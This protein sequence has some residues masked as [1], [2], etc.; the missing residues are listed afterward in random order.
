VDAAEP[1]VTG[2]DLIPPP[3]S[4][5]PNV[6]ESNTAILM[7]AERAGL[8]LGAPAPVDLHVPAPY[9]AAPGAL[10]SIPAGTTVDVHFVH[11]DPVGAGGVVNRL[12]TIEMPREILG[13]IVTTSTLQATDAT[14]GLAA[15]TYPA[16]GTHPDRQLE[17]NGEDLIDIGTD[18]RTITLDLTTSTS[19]DQLRIITL[20]AGAAPRITSDTAA[21]GAAP[22]SVVTGAAESN[23]AFTVFVE[24]AGALAVDVAVDTTAPGTYTANAQLAGGTIAAGT[25]VTSYLVHL[26]SVGGTLI[27]RRGTITFQGPILGVALRTATLDASDAACGSSTT[28]YPVGDATREV[29]LGASESLLWSG[30]GRSLRFDLGVNTGADQLRVLVAE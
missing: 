4:V 19:A 24:R 28:T 27:Y 17:L 26:D 15:V 1:D 11:F 5:V 20:A 29:E 6:T 22:A 9:A 12:A 25:R 2:V 21:V 16:A 14:L 13:V 30:D 10:A 7:F 3:A 8:T 23:T 18:R